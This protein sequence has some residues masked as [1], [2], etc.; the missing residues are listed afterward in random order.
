MKRDFISILDIEKELED[1][2]DL[3]IKLKVKIKSGDEFRPL[4]GKHLGMIFEKPS[5]RTRVSFEIGFSHLG[6]T[7]LYLSPNEIQVGKRESVYDVA[8]V[9]S[10]YVDLIMYRAFSNKIMRELAQN[11]DVPVVN[12]LD[13]LEHPCQILADLQTV[14]EH[15][16]KLQ[17]LKL[18]YLGDGNNVCNSLLLGCALTGMHMSVGCPSSYGPDP[19]ILEKAREIAAK[20]NLRIEVVEDPAQAVKDADVVYTDTWVSMGDEAEI[21]Q[22]KRMFPPYQVNAQLVSHADPEYVF[23]HCLPAHRNEEVTDE[24]MDGSHSA[25]FDQAENRMWAQM[26]IMLKLIAPATVDDL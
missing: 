4:K 12:G 20:K 2:L 26:A 14:K 17:G 7:A 10:R 6:G 23:L 18:V 9:I 8:K 11:A 1:V 5:L 19:G 24:I 13:D 21:E 15:K 25:V 22:R 16:G 3:A